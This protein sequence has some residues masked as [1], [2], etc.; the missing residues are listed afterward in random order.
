MRQKAERAMIIKQ[1]LYISQFDGL[2]TRAGPHAVADGLL[3]PLV[4][5]R[6]GKRLPP[7]LLTNPIVC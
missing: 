2:K 5:W 1:L 6:Q 3:V 7:V 4:A